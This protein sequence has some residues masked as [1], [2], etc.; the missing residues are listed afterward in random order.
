MIGSATTFVTGKAV[1]AKDTVASGLEYSGETA[2][3]ES[4]VGVQNPGTV[5]EKS[6]PDDE[7][8]KETGSP[9]STKLP[10]SGGGSGAEENY[11][12]ASDYLPEKEKLSPE[13]EDKAFSEMIN[14][15]LN[16]GGE[17]KAT[18]AK[19]VEVTA[20]KI[21][22]GEVSEEKEHGEAAAPEVEGGGMVGRIKGAYNYW[23]GGTTEEVKPKSPVSGHESS[24]SLDSTAGTKGFSDSSETGLGEIGGS[25]GSLPVQKGL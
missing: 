23:V 11:V 7:K 4:P 18:E 12:Q 9:V 24:Q 22:S 15:K 20:E 21:P 13:E 14:G 5:A 10:L 6:I 16:L 8:V 2:G 3:H 1:A 17:T 19:E 25:T